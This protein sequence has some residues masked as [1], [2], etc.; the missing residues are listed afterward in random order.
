MGGVS[1]ATSN[2]LTAKTSMVRNKVFF[3]VSEPS[4][5]NSQSCLICSAHE[6]TFME[7]P[8][9]QNTSYPNWQQEVCSPS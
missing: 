8:Q 7:L 3:L 5:S 4:D 6:T 9:T 1:Y 2:V